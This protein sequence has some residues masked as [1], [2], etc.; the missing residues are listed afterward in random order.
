MHYGQRKKDTVAE[1]AGNKEKK[2]RI[3]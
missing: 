2:P 1:I 3:K